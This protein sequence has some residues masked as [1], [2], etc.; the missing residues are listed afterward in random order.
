MGNTLVFLGEILLRVLGIPWLWEFMA[1][2]IFE[3]IGARSV[4]CSYHVRAFPL[5]PQLPL[6]LVVMPV[7]FST[8]SSILKEFG[9][10][11]LL[12]KYCFGFL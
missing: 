11:R 10:I 9:L 4:V 3:T 7:Y 8:R 1:L 12:L 2:T 5:W 6:F